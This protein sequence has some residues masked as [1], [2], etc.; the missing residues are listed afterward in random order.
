MQ[1]L[2]PRSPRTASQAIEKATAA[3][4]AGTPHD[5]ILMDMQMPRMD[6]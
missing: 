6:G 4:R 5:L 1:P 3:M 2:T